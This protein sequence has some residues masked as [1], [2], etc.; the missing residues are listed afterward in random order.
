MCRNP[1]NVSILRIVADGTRSVPA[2]LSVRSFLAAVVGL[3][4]GTF[5][6]PSADDLG[7][8][9]KANPAFGVVASRL[10][11]RMNV[12]GTVTSGLAIRWLRAINTAVPEVLVAWSDRANLH[13]KE[14]Q[15]KEAIECYEFLLE[16][17]PGNEQVTEALE[18]ARKLL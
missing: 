4:A 17:L 12:A 2:T 10:A 7:V 6:R 15:F 11:M 18:G 8:A 13:L 3:G 1:R 16:K 14:K 9:L 5:D